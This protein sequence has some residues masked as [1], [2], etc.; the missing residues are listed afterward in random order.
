MTLYALTPRRR[1]GLEA[2]ANVS[3]PVD[4]A[5]V[6]AAASAADEADEIAILVDGTSEAARMSSR[7]PAAT[8]TMSAFLPASIMPT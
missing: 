7:G 2:A 4:V 1:V 3:G 6:R 8:M 5:E